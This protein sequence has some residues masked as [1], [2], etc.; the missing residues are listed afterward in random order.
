MKTQ[1]EK[2]KDFIL[3][4]VEAHPAEI[5]AMT[6]QTFG[7]TRT[8]VH[9]H[10]SRLRD[11]GQIIQSGT[12][13][14]MKYFLSDAFQREMHYSIDGH[15]NEFDILQKDFSSAFKQL[16]EKIR[17]IVDYGF[18]EI[19]NNAFD[20]SR[21]TKVTVSITFEGA[22]V[23]ICIQDDGIGIF[24]NI[25]NYF[26]LDDIRESILQLNKG[27][28]TTDPA[29]HTGEGIFFSSRVFD[30]FEIYANKLHY[31][32]DN[33]VDDW[34]IEQLPK[35]QKGSLVCMR[36]DSN[37]TNDLIATFKK[38]QKPGGLAFDRTEI[39]VALSQF[40]QET[41]ISRSQAKRIVLG[42]EKFRQVTLDFSGIR[43]VGQGFVDEIFR[44]YANAHPQ[45]EIK[46]IH[47][48]NDVRFMIE[49]CLSTKR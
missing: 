46:Y 23:V 21:G 12:T 18:T 11:D 28:M 33:K 4:H 29:N 45:L 14:N 8:T 30:S 47:A 36:I 26:K 16:P 39:L 25:Y 20:H 19:L 13:R 17:D 49:R 44:V 37:S 9:R 10:L 48:N 5:V 6:M 40:G 31:L 34:T 22:V 32:R 7:V 27:K 35:M 38:Y 2:I 24:Q 15:P 1:A 3:Q 41:L 43:L 42:L